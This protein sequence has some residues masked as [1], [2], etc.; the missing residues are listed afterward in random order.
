MSL[1]NTNK[2]IVIQTRKGNDIQ[3]FQNPEISEFNKNYF[4]QI[5]SQYRNAIKRSEPTGLYNCHGLTF[6]NR[7]C[8]I[9]NTKQVIMILADDDY[10][11]VNYRNALPGDIIVYYSDGDVEHSGIVIEKS[12]A[13]TFVPKIFSKWSC[14]SEFIHYANYCPYDKCNI[15]YYRIIK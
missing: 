14:H 1:L 5:E 7:R 12:E 10:V 2:S 6:A 11:E 8:F 4:Q 3:N 15:K 13:P 9:E